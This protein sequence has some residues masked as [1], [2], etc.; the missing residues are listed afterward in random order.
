[1]ACQRW[2]PVRLSLTLNFLKQ[3]LKVCTLL[4]HIFDLPSYMPIPS[5]C[6]FVIL[7]LIFYKLFELDL[8]VFRHSADMSDKRL[9]VVGL[10]GAI[11]M[12]QIYTGLKSAGHRLAHTSQITIRLITFTYRRMTTITRIPD[13]IRQQGCIWLLLWIA[14]Y[15]QVFLVLYPSLCSL[16]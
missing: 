5:S 15:C 8:C 2:S 7:I 14:F 11:E 10:E 12:G 3:S 6:L 4:N 13:N 9:E 1:M 16:E